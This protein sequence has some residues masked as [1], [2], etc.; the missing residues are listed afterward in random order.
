MGTVRGTVDPDVT[1]EHGLGPVRRLRQFD[2]PQD[3]SPAAGDVFVTA[4]APDNQAERGDGRRRTRVRDLRGQDVCGSWQLWGRAVAVVGRPVTHAAPPC[5]RPPDGTQN[6]C[7]RRD[8]GPGTTQAA[9]GVLD[10]R[11][12]Q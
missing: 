5:C 9:T 8:S 7:D 2:Q 3:V 12:C 11:Q 6:T 4:D 10:C 1:P